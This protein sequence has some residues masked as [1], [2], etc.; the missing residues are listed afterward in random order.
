MEPLE[1]IE[2][3]NKKIAPGR[4]PSY[5]GV[6]VIKALEII[7][8]EKTVGRLRLSKALGLGEG[9]TRTL[10]K[11]LKREKLIDISKAGVSFTEYGEKIF[12]DFRSKIG[13]KIEIPESSLTLGSFN[14]AIL[15]R[16]LAQLVNDGLE[17]RDAA[18][19]VGAL[20]ATTLIFKDNH[21]IMP[22]ETSIQTNPLYRLLIS[23]LNPD[24]N[25]VIIIGS[26]NDYPTAEFGAMTAMYELLKKQLNR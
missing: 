13:K 3:I 19:K 8:A 5:I 14:V 15:G 18:I 20:G 17:Q 23:R 26:G 16:N 1:I 4:Q 10:I 6:H 21:L 25:D 2:R 24:E 12:Q 9:V 22:K 11:H 7:D